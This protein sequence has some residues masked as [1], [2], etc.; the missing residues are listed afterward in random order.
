MASDLISELYDLAALQQQHE[1]VLALIGEFAKV[2]G[3]AKPISVKLEGTDKTKE[4]LDG[5][6]QIGAASQKMAETVNA[7]TKEFTKLQE[8]AKNTTASFAQAKTIMESYSGTL[9]NNIAIQAK[10]KARL[11]EI[12]KALKDLEQFKG[13]GGAGGDQVVKQVAELTKE[14][15]Q[16]KQASSELNSVIKTQVKEMQ[17]AGGSNDEMAARVG[18]L[19]N[20]YRALSAEA[21][22]SDF[23]KSL[24]EQIN[25]IDTALKADDASIGNYFRNVG[26]YAGSLKAPFEALGQE[27]AKLKQEQAGLK[28]FSQRDQAGFKLSGQQDQ[29]AKVTSQIQQLEN[30]QRTGFQV[31]GSQAQQYQV[32]SNALEDVAKDGTVSADV[33]QRLNQ[34]LATSKPQYA[35]AFSDAFKVLNSELDQVRQKLNDP[36]LSGKQLESLK[37]EEQLLTVLTESLSKGFSSS[38][39]EVRAFTEASVQMGLKLGTTNKSVLEFQKAVGHGKNEVEDLKKTVSFQSSDTKYLDGI[40]SSLHGLAGVYGTVTAASSIFS[41]QDEATA[42]QMQKLQAA[43]TLVTSLQAVFNSLQTESGAIQLGLEVKTKLL[44]AAES[45]LG[46]TKA[47]VSAAT[48]SATVTTGEQIAVTETAIA[49][50]V[51]HTSALEGEAAALVTESEAAQI[52]A[53]ATSELAISQEAAAVTGGEMAVANGGAAVSSETTTGALITQT[54]ATIATEAATSSL[55]ATLLATGIGAIV[56]GI[57]AGIAYLVKVSFDWA[58]STTKAIERQEKVSEAIQKVNQ[59]L[60]DQATVTNAADNAMKRY[61]ENQNKLSAAAG[62]SQEKQLARKKALLLEDKRLAEQQITSLGFNTVGDATKKEYELLSKI[63]HIQA[64]K[65]TYADN[66]AKS[67]GEKDQYNIL[68]INTTVDANEKLWESEENKLQAILPFYNAV[69]SAKEAFYSSG[70]ALE[71]HKTQVDKLNEDERRKIILEGVRIEADLIQNK[72]NLILSNDR[73]T[74]SQRLAAMQSNAAEQKKVLEAEKNNVL[75]DKAS[76]NTDGSLTADATNAIKKANAEEQKITL[77]SAEAERKLKEDYRLRDLVALENMQKLEFQ[78]SVDLNKSI[79]SNDLFS[80][81]Q[82]TQALQAYLAKEK[83][84]LDDEYKLKLQQAGFTDKEIDAYEKTGKFQIKNKKLTAAEIRSIT[85]E[86]ENGILKLNIESNE[87][88]T[89]NLETELNKRKELQQDALD[90][91]LRKFNLAT[92]ATTS[93]YSEDV[94]A[95]NNSLIAKEVSITQYNKR[96]EAIDRKY[97]LNTVQNNLASLKEQLAQFTNA[98]QQELD[99]QT[100]VD[101]LKQDLTKATTDEEKKDIATKLE[102]AKKEL[103]NTEDNANKKI[104]L[105]KQI[106]DLEKQASDESTA[107]QKANLEKLKQAYKELEGKALDFIQ[108]LGDGGY[109]RQNQQ[110]QTQLDL[111]DKQKNKDTEFVNQTVVNAAEKEKKLAEINARSDAKKAQL[112]KQQKRNEYEKAK[113]DRE[114]AIMKTIIATARAVVEALPNIPLSI[115]VGAIGAVEIATIL[116]TPL[117]KYFAGTQ[118]HPGGLA[119]VGDGGVSEYVVT[120]EGQVSK[121]PSVPTLMDLPEHSKV[122]KDEMAFMDALA[123]AS[124]RESERKATA[125]RQDNNYW[126]QLDKTMGKMS[127]DIVQAIKSAP[128]PVI[129]TVS[130]IK[131]WVHGTGS[132]ETIF[133]L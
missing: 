68:G 43:L 93:K 31:T 116:S 18:L 13:L 92:N 59:A 49:T 83:Q 14:Q 114:I 60:I 64:L 108:A 57:A 70:N 109:D 33:V 24:K 66:I 20:Q 85:A 12:K 73:S 48:Q 87:A 6:K 74:L 111:V 115:A 123:F 81:E 11:D 40:V 95:L 124:I 102:E 35:G 97:Q 45:I 122:Y 84:L 82:R 94:I 128:Q 39:Q 29:L 118:D 26:N 25:E 4:I 120:P 8:M 131:R 7:A 27:I 50:E 126:K 44:A 119:I 105:V 38:K 110:I 21:K 37:Q 63:Q 42:K 62:E 96:R 19:R 47:A 51:Q 9:D 72:N 65:Q 36:S 79:A 55:A 54:G 32:L 121:T 71:E 86:H 112:E 53:G 67:A 10:Y 75:N 16:L 5:I 103:K 69:K 130:P 52:A 99:A 28:D 34:A 1:K 88:A 101:K 91:I 129:E 125:P 17:A 61:Y 46:K 22:N 78:Y 100:K 41:D 104:A 107:K 2:A 133:G 98:E 127:K 58:T 3:D 106:A 117:P 132:S 76:K 23:G 56:V 30:V 90:D 80:F 89:K 113:F 77:Q 15:L